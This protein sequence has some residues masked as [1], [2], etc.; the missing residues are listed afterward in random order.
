MANILNI[1]V[2]A[3]NAFQRQLATT[4]QNIANVNTEG[5][6]RQRV[7][8]ESLAP[9]EGPTGRIGSGV[10][11]ASIRRSY[12]DYLANGVRSYTASHQEY[13]ILQQRASQIDNVIGDEA[14]GLNGMMQEFFASIHDVSVDPTSMPARTV[15]L[16]R[17]EMLSDR[18][19]S[20]DGWME[21]QRSDL[22]RDLVVSVD[23]ANGIVK[24]IAGINRR[25]QSILTNNNFPPND[26]LDQ[27]DRLL[28]EL[29]GYVDV[30]AR[31]QDDGAMNV[32]IGKGQALVL[33][34]S[35]G[36]LSVSDGLAAG[37]KKELMI[38]QGGNAGAV[39][40][41][42]QISGGKLG[43]L[44]R[45]RNEV[46]DP[47]QDN[48]GLV[49]I[50]LAHNFN[51]QHTA[52][53]DLDGNAGVALFGEA[54][55]QVLADNSNSGTG[56]L[57]AVFDPATV[58][59]L[60]GDEYSI[61]YDGSDW[62]ISTSPGGTPTLLGGN[63]VY[64][65]EG[66]QLTL[67]GVASAGDNFVLR[68]TR[69]GAADMTTS[70]T[71]PRDIAAAQSTAPGDN[72]NALALAD[73]QNAGSLL[74][75]TAT[76]A[77]VYAQMVADVGTRTHQAGTNAEVHAQLLGQAENAK[78]AVSGVNLD[79]EAANLVRFQQAYSAAAQ[80][81]ATANTLFDTLLGAVRR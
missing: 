25:I 18:F 62:S 71:D 16:N 50:G 24:S 33:G 9:V 49:A 31:L 79:E 7:D 12:D 47:A 40:V 46:L 5:Y 15:M 59:N 51:A 41:T 81:I 74:G 76:V 63:G 28:D 6:N 57:A 1:G 37:D 43:G 3:L 35:A 22:N 11:V 56:T 27:R 26:L 70:I 65:H 66:V 67:G 8:L 29:S 55:P 38:T 80:V 14:A 77:D 72:S 32:F 23:E 39:V 45:Y 2:N 73:L 60:S 48:L 52:G 44:L 54:A 58:N 61:S 10:K 42:Q 78:A 53:F 69:A 19:R 4:G 36:T 17:A 13:S 75:G 68:P 20:L 34:N 21:D 30:T 64:V